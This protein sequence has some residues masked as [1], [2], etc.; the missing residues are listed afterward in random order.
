MRLFS[1]P[2]AEAR[3]LRHRI[4]GNRVVVQMVAIVAGAALT[5]MAGWRYSD[6]ASAWQAAVRVE[7]ARSGVYQDDVR[8]VYANE[9]PFAFRVAATEVRADVLAPLA[10]RNT[11]AATQQEIA[12]QTAF[13]LRSAADP[14]TLLGERR[15][16]LPDGGSNLPRRLADVAAARGPAPDPDVPDRQGDRLARLAGWTA[17]ATALLTGLAVVGAC[18]HRPRRRRG[19]APSRNFTPEPLQFYPQPVEVTAEQR[20]V[21]FLLLAVWAAGVLIPLIQLAF[22]SQEQ[23]YQADS[24]RHTVQ[25]RSAKS[26]SLTRTEF[27]LNARQIAQ[28]G[29]VAATARQIDA[30]YQDDQAVA[31]AG[32][33]ARA[34]ETAASRSATVAETM[35]EVPTPA[36]G[37][38]KQLAAALGTQQY[39]WDY[40]AALS[41]WE[42]RKADNAGLFSN[43]MLGLI[44]LIVLLEVVVH[45]IAT[46]PRS[47]SGS[48]HRTL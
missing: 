23:R 36:H 18:V 44:G 29:N 5:F 17:V 42:T 21:A 14:G 11:A 1:R 35:A 16:D 45:L 7:V 48:R 12:T 41:A 9:G 8:R 20:R 4:G 34:E 46:R 43:F 39:D 26:I 2:L 30:N 37:I 32:E 25:A 28:E 38:E 19:S 27:L 6:A 31:E 10:D 15:Y 40:L 47:H 22:S 24:A 13:A 33:L 3:T